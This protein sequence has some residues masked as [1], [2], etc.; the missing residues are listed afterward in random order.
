M[1]NMKNSLFV[2]IIASAVMARFVVTLA[3]DAQESTRSF[4]IV[5]YLPDYRFAEFDVD[6]AQGLTDLVLFSAEPQA[7][8]GLD[9]SRLKGCP[10]QNLLRFK[11]RQRIRLLLSVGGWDRST[12]FA[13]AAGSERKRRMFAQTVV[14]YCQEQRLDGVDVDWE[15]PGNDREARD[16]GLLLSELR[17]AFEPNGLLLTVT[18][19]AWQTLTP[20]AI[21]AADFV[22]VMAYD[23]PGRHSTFEGSQADVD[24]LR[25][26]GVPSEKITLGVPFYGR[27][28]QDRQ[29]MTYAEI[30]S[31]FHPDPD[32]DQSGEIYFNGPVTIRH[33]TVFALQTGLGGIMVWEIGQ[34]APGQASLLKVIRETVDTRNR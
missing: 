28:V 25:N 8:G 11:T 6:A 29:A 1:S 12:H 21:Q 22:Q 23:H 15:H 17:T 34:D 20:A 26:R 3:D 27:H 30:V 18:V 19:A 13:A 2:M 9:T 24:S 5:G 10:W 31:R 33:K 14:R 7:D 16:Y 32:A 4:R